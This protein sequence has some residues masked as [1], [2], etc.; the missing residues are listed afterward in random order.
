MDQQDE[1]RKESGENLNIVSH[2]SS[3]IKE[4]KRL[5][6]DVATTKS[7]M[8][9]HQMLPNHLRRRAMSHNPKR[10]PLRYRNGHKAQM[11]KS[12]LENQKSKRPS[13]KYRRKPSNLMKEYNRRKQKNVWLETHI[14]HAKRFKMKNMF[15]Y[16]IPYTPTDKRY[17]TSYKAVRH[18]C[19][20][21]DI[22]YY[23]CIEISGPIDILKQN[24]SRITS[25]ECGL[26]LN[27]QSL[28]NGTR[29]G[30][31]ML[32]KKDSYPRHALTRVSFLWRPS[33]N[34]SHKTIWI[35]VH[36]CVYTEV[37]QEFIELFDADNKSV[38]GE[39]CVTNSSFT[40]NP[41]YVNTNSKMEILELKD[42]LNRLRL[43]GPFTNAVLS[44][45]LKLATKD[46]NNWIE[47]LFESNPIFKDS[48]AQQGSVW[49]DLK[50]AG[51]HLEFPVHGILGLIV[52]DPR[53]NR[54]NSARREKAVNDPNTFYA[55]N[56]LHDV[57]KIA[58]VSPLWEKDVRDELLKTKMTNSDLCKLRNKNQLVPGSA[59]I[60]EKT[61]LQPVPIILIQRP[62]ISGFGSG[63]DIIIPASY[64]LHFW[65]S[66]IKF[67]AKASGFR[68]MSMIDIES[69]CDTFEPDTLLGRKEYETIRQN[70]IEKYFRLPPNK[71]TNFTKMKIASPFSCPF[72]QLT[73]EWN[74]SINDDF[75]ILRNVV[76]LNELDN[77]IRKKEKINFKSIE[78]NALIPIF[79][80][81]ER[82]NC[83]VDYSFDIICLPKKCDIK[84]AL[85]LKYYKSR[86]PVLIETLG[87]DENTSARK[88][89]RINHKKMLKRLRNQR[90]KIKRKLQATSNYFVKIPKCNS[91]KVIEEQYKEMCKLWLPIESSSIR[92]QCSREVI[93]YVTR[94][95]FRF[96]EGK[97][98]A[99]GYVTRDGLKEL[100]QVFQKFK[101]LKHFVMTR[102]TNSQN[103]YTSDF[104]INNQ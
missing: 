48:H 47:K 49:T 79:L 34:T 2:I 101:G 14:W 103:Y 52:E 91:E 44:K 50:A 9:I 7:E 73:Y 76:R 19:L 97:V 58:S 84:K 32:F 31:V 72:E 77:A 64:G 4:L 12:G 41:R 39:N 57:P 89:I 78:V 37:L 27:A 46:Q 71:R 43:S 70:E 40:R 35:F 82:G 53:L 66:L 90:V 23:S 26:T 68:E 54:S 85:T 100:N 29:E 93:G 63:F 18:H 24:F 28:M 6:N 30:H 104:S 69:R 20:A 3:R 51:S 65:L 55:G 16:R 94:T 60:F 36:P 45:T 83:N 75:Y 102:S 42:T 87:C 22:S 74:A 10:L 33:E 59:S 99:I 56:Y 8:L 1:K 11:L 80:F 25:I 13:R 15:G 88:T 98:C 17:R 86:E 95:K 61:H 38:N 62:N 96:S 67:G 81:N 21:Q 92:N 5:Y